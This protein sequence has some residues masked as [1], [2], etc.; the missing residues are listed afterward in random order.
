MQ[1]IS[2]VE[3][4]LWF[5]YLEHQ[6]VWCR[7]LDMLQKCRHVDDFKRHKKISE[8]SYGIVYRGED[9]KTHKVV[10]LKKVHFHTSFSAVT[11]FQDCHLICGGS[12]IVEVKSDMRDNLN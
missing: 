8:G 1:I 9:L 2:A 10:A 12:W 5:W 7:S 3:P 6:L 4:I 11:P